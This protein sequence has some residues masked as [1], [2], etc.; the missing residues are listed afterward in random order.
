VATELTAEDVAA[1][2]QRGWDAIINK[3]LP[4]LSQ[5]TSDDLSYTDTNSKV[6]DKAAHVDSIR[7]SLNDFQVV[8]RFDTNI[9]VK[10]NVARLTGRA[11]VDLI[12]H[13]RPGT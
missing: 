2:E 11:D 5:L 8:R 4:V 7:T 6:E 12:A 10:S 1:L 3:H 13:R 9:C